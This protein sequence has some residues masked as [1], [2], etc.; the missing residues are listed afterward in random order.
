M[1]AESARLWAD[2][3]GR[4]AFFAATL[5]ELDSMFASALR[6]HFGGDRLESPKRAVL[7]GEVR[8]DA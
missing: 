6:D 4:E 8:A 2:V 1:G 5:A 7:C 3:V